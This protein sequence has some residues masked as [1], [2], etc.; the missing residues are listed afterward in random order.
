MTSHLRI[1]QY[2]NVKY[3]SFSPVYRPAV[4]SYISRSVAPENPH[5]S[6]PSSLSKTT[7]HDNKFCVCHPRG[8]S[9]PIVKE[10]HKIQRTKHLG[11]RTSASHNLRHSRLCS[12]NVA[13]RS[14]AQDPRK[15]QSGMSGIATTTTHENPTYHR[16][17]TVLVQNFVQASPPHQP[18]IATQPTS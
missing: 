14:V 3:H 2:C 1:L 6:P 15:S 10:K 16:A 8:Q 7:H 4:P 18:Q 11:Q 5:R 12:K 17:Q 13:K 9:R